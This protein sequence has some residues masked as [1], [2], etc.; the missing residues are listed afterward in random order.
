MADQQGRFFPAKVGMRGTV[1]MTLDCAFPNRCG[2]EFGPATGFARKRCSDG[3][4]R[5]VADPRTSRVVAKL[6]LVVKEYGA[7]AYFELAKIGDGL[8]LF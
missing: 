6:R 8:E 7:A 1:R 5:R 4:L 2:I 3:K